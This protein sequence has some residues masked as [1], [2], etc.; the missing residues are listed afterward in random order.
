MPA[1]VAFLLHMHQPSYVDPRTG[2]A[3]LPW[4]RLHAAS[5]YL[6]VATALDDEPAMHL[7]VNFVPSLV[8]QLEGLVNG[9]SCAWEELS[10]RP[11][12]TLSADD[13]G[14]ILERFFSVNWG[15]S[16]EPRARYRELLDKRG[17]SP[18]P[19]EL[20][21]R[22]GL[23]SDG[24]LRDLS[25][26]FNLAWIGW[27]A[28]RGDAE[29]EKL[30]KKGRNFDASDLALVLGRIRAAAAKVLPLWR[31]LAARGQVELSASPFYH[32]IVPLLCDGASAARAR[33]DLP[34]PK[35]VL[36]AP[37]DAR[38]QIVRGRD[39]HTRAFGVAPAGMWPPEGSVSDEA[40]A[41][42][43]EAGVG[44]L[45][46][47]EGILW[48]S[49]DVPI[50]RGSLYRAWRREGVDLVFR[51]REISDRLGFAYAHGDTDA[52]VNDLMRRAE[53]AAASSTAPADEAL[54]PIILDG[55]NA[56][57]AYPGG[58]E[59]FLRR[60]FATLAGSRTLK[61]VSIGEHL[62]R[63]KSRATLSRLHAGSWIDSDFHIWSGDPVK[64]RGWELVA[65]VR[66]RLVAA[67]ARGVD[68]AKLEAARES[69]S[70]AEG[71]DWF[72]WFGE[73][74]HS[75]E[76][77][78]F[79]KLFRTHLAAVLAAIGEPIMPALELPVGGGPSSAAPVFEAP[80]ALIRPGIA[81]GGA[82]SAWAWR[83]SGRFRVPRGAAMA[84]LPLLT[85]VR[86]GFDAERLFVRAETA[87]E[88]RVELTAA[89]WELELRL[90]A[91]VR[92][93]RGGSDGGWRIWRADGDA[94]I[95][96]GVGTPG[97]IWPLENPR[98]MELGVPLSRLELSPGQVIEVVI[99]VLR[100]EV[101][102]GR[103][104]TDGALPF[105][106]PDDGFEA[107]NWTV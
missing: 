47:D 11:P 34:L 2:R 10:M 77:A 105:T 31:K 95:D 20:R 1:S 62:A 26:L 7:T 102:L 94:F 76:D 68:E 96:E 92:R 50:P 60:L 104:P 18:Q 36:R 106:V 72:W 19:G 63:A 59:P 100:S 42:Y 103:F 79:D 30:E 23:F 41:V 8:A 44:W 29:L 48:R 25:V 46:T 35:R 97:A 6:D 32:P 85:E 90:G 58:G 83:G 16:V 88:R 45:A 40:L 39:A 84:V 93:I 28:R 12:S 61:P 38:R 78:L 17:R 89:E 98:V 22:G 53:A 27:A 107:E 5:A 21:Q 13:R 54:V 71:S 82:T 24:E 64:N 3:E 9:A 99:R 52:S 15:R 91:A 43:A 87:P 81:A 66:S 80:F 67:T 101:T 69:L 65:D 37:D 33:P 73:P 55:E 14:S 75:N 56:W 86:F 70:A 49:I 51:D 57:A 4:V 74:F